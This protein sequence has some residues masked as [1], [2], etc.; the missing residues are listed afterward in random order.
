GHLPR[1]TEGQGRREAE[2]HHGGSRTA[3][4]VPHDRLLSGGGAGGSTLPPPHRPGANLHLTPTRAHRAAPKQ[5]SSFCCPASGRAHASCVTVVLTWTA[6]PDT[7]ETLRFRDFELDVS[8]YQLRRQGQ[9]VRLE[10]RPM[11]LLIMLVERRR[12]LVTRTEIVDRLWGK[13]V[14]V[15]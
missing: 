11:D 15:D 12:Q 5:T 7:R 9:A 1:G 4:F 8:A 13:D 14:F 6:M 10:R 2:R 3:Q